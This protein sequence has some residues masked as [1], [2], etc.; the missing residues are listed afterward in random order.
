M[1]FFLCAAQRGL[2]LD[3]QQRGSDRRLLHGLRALHGP[4]EL[5]ARHPAR[6]EHFFCRISIYS[7][8]GDPDILSKKSSKF[9]VNSVYVR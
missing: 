5:R 1:L 8:E 9:T 6:C 4:G 3:V 7:L 2:R